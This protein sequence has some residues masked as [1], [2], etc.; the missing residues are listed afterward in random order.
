MINLKFK[1]Q[2]KR[3]L[4]EYNYKD[5]FEISLSLATKPRRPGKALYGL[6]HFKER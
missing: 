5:Y 4:F 2:I 1:F 3:G 6:F